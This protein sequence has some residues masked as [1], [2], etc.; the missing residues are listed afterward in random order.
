MGAQV[1]RRQDSDSSDTE[2]NASRD[3]PLSSL[4]APQTSGDREVALSVP[5]LE[6]L[7]PKSMTVKVRQKARQIAAMEGGVQLEGDDPDV[8]LTASYSDSCRRVDLATCECDCPNPLA[9]CA[10]C[11][12]R[13]KQH[14]AAR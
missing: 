11:M 3:P 7:L 12:V 6:V 5:D 9:L 4:F 10:P 8:V 2:S 14:S 13:Q 1:A